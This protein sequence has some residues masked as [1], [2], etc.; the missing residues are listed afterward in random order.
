[1]VFLADPLSGATETFLGQGVLG[2]VCIMLIGAVVYQTRQLAEER[3]NNSAALDQQRKEAQAE[4]ETLRQQL[5]QSEQ[6][7]IA[8]AQARVAD[9]KEFR[10]FLSDFQKGE[11]VTVNQLESVTE[12][13]VRAIDDLRRVSK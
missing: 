3:K 6:G 2:A 7:R 1:M 12:N 9:A 10:Q 11:T 13:L 8:E 4:R 5:V